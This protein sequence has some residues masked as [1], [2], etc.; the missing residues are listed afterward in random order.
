MIVVL[1]IYKKSRFKKI[2]S[3]IL[4]VLILITSLLDVGFLGPWVWCAAPKNTSRKILNI[5][6]L[7]LKS[8]KSNRFVSLPTCVKTLPLKKTFLVG[9]IPNWYFERYQNFLEKY[10]NEGIYF[11]KILG[12]LDGQKIFFSKSIE[13]KTIENYL[14]DSERYSQEF[15][16]IKYN[17][18]IL[19][20]NFK[21]STDGYLSFIDNWDKDWTAYVDGQPVSVELLFDTFKSVKLSSG[22]HKVTFIYNP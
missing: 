10:N 3:N 2:N 18:D 21:A 6:E 19:S 20:L 9:I 1:Y 17:G 5:E 15:E 7:N 14:K 13:H 12:I 8:F 16:I 22:T 11:K 4:L